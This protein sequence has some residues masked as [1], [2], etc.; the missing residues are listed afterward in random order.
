[1]KVLLGTK[2]EQTF[3]PPVGSLTLESAGSKTAYTGAQRKLVKV[4]MTKLISI[5]GEYRDV[6]VE[7]VFYLDEIL[8]QLKDC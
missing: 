5:D 7:D 4:R 1:M 6:V 2:V 8:G 3:G